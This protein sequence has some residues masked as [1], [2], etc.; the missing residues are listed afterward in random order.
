MVKNT[1]KSVIHKNEESLSI[2]EYLSMP[3][4]KV[5]YKTGDTGKAAYFAEILE[6][7]S[8]FAEGDSELTALQNLNNTFKAYIKLAKKKQMPIPM[9]FATS[10][11]GGKVLVRMPPTLHYRLSMIAKSEGVSL[12]QYIVN[13]IVS[14]MNY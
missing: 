9:P 6:L 7:N 2:E 8:C 12:N 14:G 3:Y 11:Y 5:V 10:D 1:N 4:K 13:A